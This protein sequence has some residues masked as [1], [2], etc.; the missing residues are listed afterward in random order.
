MTKPLIP[1]A[2]HKEILRFAGNYTLGK[3]TTVHCCQTTPEG[4]TALFDNGVRGLLGLYGSEETPR[5]SYS[6]PESVAAKIRNGKI[7]R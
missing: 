5:T 2:V 7:E 1:N 6:L 3:T 4:V